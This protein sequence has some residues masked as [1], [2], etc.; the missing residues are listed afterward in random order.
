MTAS[1]LS[2]KEPHM[3]VF[4]MF[5][6]LHRARATGWRL[7]AACL[8]VCVVCLTCPATLHG[9]ALS[10]ITGTVTDTTGGV[11]GNV[12]ITV[13]NTATLVASHSVTSS[14]GTYTVTDLNA[15]TYTV[16]AESPGFQTAVHNGV[17]VEVGRPST[18]NASLQT[19]NVTQ[20]VEVV[21]NAITLNTTQPELGTTVENA[22]VQALPVELDAGDGRGR[23]IDSFIFLAPGVTGG[24][25]SKRINGG[26]DFESEVVF[27]GIPMAQSETQ[28]FQTIWNP[29]FEQVSEFN[30][31]TS[32]FSAQYGLAQGV[33]TY[34]TAS[35]TNQFHGDGFEILRNS[36]FDA[37]GAYNATVP[38]DRENNYGFTIAGPVWVPKL[39]NGKNKLFFHLSMEWYRL[40]Q[41]DLTYMSLPT[42]AEKAGNFTATGLTIYNPTTHVPFPNDTIPQSMISPLSASLIPLMPNPTY[43]GYVNNFQSNEGVLPTRQNPWG[44]NIDY[45]LTSN[46]SLHWSTWRDKQ[47]SYG[48]ETASHL[49]G[50]LGS[51]TVN[52]DLGTVFLLNYSNA[53]TPHLVITAGASWLGELNDQISLEKNVTFAPD[54]GTPELPAIN[55]SGPLAPTTFGSPWIQS[56]NRKLGWVLENNYLWINGKNTFNIGWELRRTYQD[57][58]ECQ[59]CAGNFNFSNNETAN[60]NALGTTGNAFASYLLGT[61]DSADRV[62]SEEEKLRNRDFS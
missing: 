6:L 53:V 19:G 55:F 9:Q 43:A 58:N 40:N 24:S 15:G 61:V 33:V 1:D 34:Q 4:S 32:S 2:D 3:R 39:F 37:R 31:L 44:F 42:A 59:Q 20:S 47:T 25:F 30:V 50:E 17:L 62:G 18:V 54:P 38:V 46:Q 13:T 29:P 10:S 60:P 16:Q 23:Q 12:K 14:S 21:E 11:M 27:N 51:E 28:G 48:T 35:G 45:N 41:P 22:V 56:I 52:P 5:P 57:D 49:L 36:F 8:A 7:L 26:V